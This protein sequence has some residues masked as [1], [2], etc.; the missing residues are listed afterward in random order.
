MKLMRI[1]DLGKEKCAVMLVDGKVVDV[2]AHVSTYDG[3][4]FERPCA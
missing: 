1:G 4:F 3:A 2:S